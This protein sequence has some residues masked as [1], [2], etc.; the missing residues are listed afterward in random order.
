MVVGFG[1]Q[2]WTLG[3]CLIGWVGVAVGNIVVVLMG[4][5]AV[6]NRI[7]QSMH[8]VIVWGVVVTRMGSFRRHNS[9]IRRL[10]AKSIVA[11]GVV[12]TVDVEARMTTRRRRQQQS[13]KTL[14]VVR[15]YHILDQSHIVVVVVVV[16]ARSLDHM[17]GVVPVH[18][19]SRA[20]AARTGRYAVEGTVAEADAGTVPGVYKHEAR[21]AFFGARDG[22]QRHP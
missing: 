14:A 3:P 17:A 13:R 4:V 7:L 11:V 19:M 15:D 18:N 20:E 16:L 21:L 10:V 8:W 12:A 9:R 2:G 5:G 22:Q 1:N 6:G